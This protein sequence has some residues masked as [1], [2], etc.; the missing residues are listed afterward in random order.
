MRKNL[1]IMMRYVINVDDD[2]KMVS[3]W[4]FEPPYVVGGFQSDFHV[5]SMVVIADEY[6]GHKSKHGISVCKVVFFYSV[7]RTHAPQ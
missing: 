3:V 4:V 5:G 7:V 2:E 1:D 6:T